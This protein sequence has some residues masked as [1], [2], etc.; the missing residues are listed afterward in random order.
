ME[1]DEFRPQLDDWLDE[2][3][4]ELAPDTTRPADLDGHMA[5]IAKVRHADVRCRM[6]PLGLAG[7]G[8]RPRG[9]LAAAGVP[10]RGVDRA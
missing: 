1:L 8:R 9:L 2:H 10:Q 7:A 5:Q 3:A 4:D 6:G